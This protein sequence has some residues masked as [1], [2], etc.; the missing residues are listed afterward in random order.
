MTTKVL[1]PIDLD[2]LA[3]FFTWDTERQIAD[4]DPDYDPVGQDV[5]EIVASQWNHDNL[6]MNWGDPPSPEA[7]NRAREYLARKIVENTTI[8]TLETIL[9]D[10]GDSYLPK[11][12]ARDAI[13]AWST[14]KA[15]SP[16][17]VEDGPS[18]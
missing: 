3:Q 15:Y 13:L 11:S 9:V 17:P 5:L 12:V 4:A 14:G 6:D 8:D 2:V 7:V 1:V 10:L 16:T 18:L